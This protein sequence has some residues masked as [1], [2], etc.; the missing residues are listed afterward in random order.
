[1]VRTGHRLGA[2][3]FAA[4]ALPADSAG[5]SQKVQLLVTSRRSRR[6]ICVANFRISQRSVYQA[7][8]RRRAVGSDM[9]S[10]LFEPRPL[11]V[12]LR[13]GKIR[14]VSPQRCAAVNQRN[15]GHAARG[16]VLP[17]VL[18]PAEGNLSNV[19]ADRDYSTLRLQVLPRF[20]VT[21]FRAT[22]CCHG[23]MHFR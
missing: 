11:K 18:P 7:S 4:W 3:I 15:L 6:R 12:G 1:M 5:R 16:S 17:S 22:G 21:N 23:K 10:A 13:I 20:Q 9:L 14:I 19:T 8:K 2:Y